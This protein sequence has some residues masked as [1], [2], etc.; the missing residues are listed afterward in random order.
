MG[1]VK[2]LI[3]N[4]IF[5]TVDNYIISHE[6]NFFTVWDK[7]IEDTKP[8]RRMGIQHRLT[9]ELNNRIWPHN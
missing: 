5:T 9:V 8:P 6:V 7:V 2:V 4:E 1:S 3:R